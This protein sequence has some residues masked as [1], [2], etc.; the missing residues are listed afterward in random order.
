MPWPKGKPTAIRK[1]NPQEIKRLYVDE[2][3]SIEKVAKRL[4]LGKTTVATWLRKLG[5][6]RNV[7]Q[8]TKLYGSHRAERN[9]NWRGGRKYKGGYIHIYKPDHPIVLA[10]K[11][12][13][14][15]VAEHIIVWEEAHLRS[16][17]PD[18]VVHHLNGIRDDN[19]SENLMA[20]PRQGHSPMLNVKE[21]QN[22]LRQVENE[23][24][25]IKSQGKLDPE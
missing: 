24:R 15:Y 4:Q 3:L 13:Y 9:S 5:V 6:Q 8:A 7:S 16:L 19:R 18:W 2:K 22:R 25:R 11:A 17:P 12:Y 14:P 10:R 20:L 1:A 21:V 23:L